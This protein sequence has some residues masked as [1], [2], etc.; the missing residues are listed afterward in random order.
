MALLIFILWFWWNGMVVNDDMSPFSN[1]GN[2]FFYAFILTWILI[3]IFGANSG[4]KK[5]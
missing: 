4:N 2:F 1:I 5:K 3:C